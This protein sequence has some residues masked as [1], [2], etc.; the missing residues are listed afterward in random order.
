MHFDAFVRQQA[1]RN[2]GRLDA[3]AEERQERLE[4]HHA[5]NREREIHDHDAQQVRQDVPRR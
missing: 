4:Q 2:V 5:R 3:Q 1:P